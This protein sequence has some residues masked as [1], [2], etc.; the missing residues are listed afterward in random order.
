M[1]DI[2]M[3]DVFEVIR[4]YDPYNQFLKIKNPYGGRLIRNNE[5][6]VMGLENGKLCAI[7]HSPVL[8]TYYRG[9]PDVYDTCFPSLYRGNPSED[10]I[11]INQLKALDF[12]DICKTFPSAQFAE[13]DGLDVRYDAISQHYGLKT[14]I[15]DITDDIS[16]A[17]YFATQQYDEDTD[18]Y[19]SITDGLGCIR[20]TEQML[21]MPGFQGIIIGV[22]PFYR[23][24]RQRAYG[25]ICKPGEN[26]AQSSTA[27]IF[28]Q[29]SQMN[30]LVNDAFEQNEDYVL[31][32]SEII[33]DAAKEVRKSSVIT[34]TSIEEYCRVEHREYGDVVQ[35][36]R[37]N[38]FEVTNYPVF[39]LTRQ[40]RR[41][42]EKK[43]RTGCPYGNLQFTSR[44]MIHSPT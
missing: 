26:F 14:N 21:G 3:N 27:V 43:I 39:K 20:M 13:K 7:A 37:S 30:K 2:V 10:T 35:I 9:E 29:D 5:F 31:F 34:R 12:Q 40:Q 22:Q 33:A 25:Y 11:L 16:V 17:A 41:M 1:T 19:H 32:P 42:L 28:K 36:L 24:A 8:F 15:I 23:T 4:H 6:H 18:S 44:L 38:G